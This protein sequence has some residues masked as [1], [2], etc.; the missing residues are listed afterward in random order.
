MLP[1]HLIEKLLS[2]KLSVGQMIFDQ[3]MWHYSRIGLGKV[4]SAINMLQ[5]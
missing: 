3:K 1:R 2:T 4:A 5:L